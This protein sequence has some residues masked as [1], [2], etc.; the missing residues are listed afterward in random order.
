MAD[1]TRD[2]RES[3]RL[4]AKA[5]SSGVDGQQ[6]SSPGCRDGAPA[7]RSSDPGTLTARF[8]NDLPLEGVAEMLFEG[9][10]SKG[11]GCPPS[12]QAGLAC[13][14]E[15]QVMN[16][17]ASGACLQSTGNRGVCV[18]TLLWVIRI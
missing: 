3:P 1:T 2:L 8:G 16:S 13:V 9:I 15:A 4:W 7:I 17:P 14:L 6:G 18:R 5:T 12:A 11:G 10:N